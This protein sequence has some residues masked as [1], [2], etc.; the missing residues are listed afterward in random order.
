MVRV[1]L[2]VRECRSKILDLPESSWRN[3]IKSFR[4]PESLVRAQLRVKEMHEE[5]FWSCVRV[6][7]GIRLR[8][9]ICTSVW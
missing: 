1:Q 4:V 7:G 3:K 8:V 6:F 2:R 9:L 5:E